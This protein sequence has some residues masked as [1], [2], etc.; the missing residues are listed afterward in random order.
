MAMNFEQYKKSILMQKIGDHKSHERLAKEIES[1][2][3]VEDIKLFYAKNLFNN[4]EVEIYIFF[5]NGFAHC[6][7]E[8]D[9]DVI[10]HYHCKPLTK[11]FIIPNDNNHVRLNV[12]Y[13]NGEQLSFDSLEDSGD[14]WYQEYIDHIRELYKIL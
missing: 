12:S 4:K 2:Y 10:T 5:E 8:E 3:K 7:L 14:N 6:T 11:H 1:L 9:R 13:D